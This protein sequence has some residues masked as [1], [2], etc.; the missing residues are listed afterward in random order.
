M[1]TIIR[2]GRPDDYATIEEVNRLAFGQENEARLVAAIRQAQGF[3][4]ALSLV[5]IRADK[6]V[7]H[8]LFSPIHIE[9]DQGRIPALALAPMAVLPKF[10]RQGIGSD[11]VRE[12]LEACRRSEHAIVVVVGHPGFY[13]RFGFYPATSH[14]IRAP[15]D[16]PD[17][18]FMILCLEQPGILEDISGVVRY[19][20]AFNEV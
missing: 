1:T 12:G 20:S 11:L 16:V 14:G 17:E 15:F 10:Q 5:A 3:D 18:A 13:P 7:G 19:P 8:I 9:S 6:L 4:E 2:P